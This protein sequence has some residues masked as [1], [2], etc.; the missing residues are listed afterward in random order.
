VS[1]AELQWWR[2][3]PTMALAAALVPSQSYLWKMCPSRGI[4]LFPDHT[5]GPRLQPHRVLS[6]HPHML[7][8]TA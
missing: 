1:L 7:R 3:T 6:Y 8:P 5:G 2:Y 4:S